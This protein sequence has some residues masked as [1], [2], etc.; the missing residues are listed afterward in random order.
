MSLKLHVFQTQL[1]VALCIGARKPRIYPFNFFF[2]SHNSQQ[3]VC[4]QCFHTIVTERSRHLPHYEC[5][6]VIRQDSTLFGLRVGILD[7]HWRSS[8]NLWIP[9]HSI[10]GAKILSSHCFFLICNIFNVLTRYEVKL[11]C[12]CVLHVGPFRGAACDNIGFPDD[13]RPGVPK[14][15]VRKWRVNCVIY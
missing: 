3:A 12:M 15:L 13:G 5:T 1:F 4:Q 7:M 10:D 11:V 8:K 14:Y 9:Q 2:G 6:Y